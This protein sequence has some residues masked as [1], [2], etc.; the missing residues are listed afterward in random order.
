[1]LESSRQRLVAL[2]QDPDYRDRMSWLSQNRSG[3][4][5]NTRELE[6]CRMLRLQGVHVSD[7]IKSRAGVRYRK[8]QSVWTPAS[9]TMARERRLLLVQALRELTPAEIAIVGLTYWPDVLDLLPVEPEIL[10]SLTAK[11][12]ETG[13]SSLLQTAMVKLLDH[14]E[15]RDLL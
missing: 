8:V 11:G 13:Y 2:W 4:N 1:M 10:E 15:L 12:G 5:K 6:V 9:I 7:P 14:D 3:Q